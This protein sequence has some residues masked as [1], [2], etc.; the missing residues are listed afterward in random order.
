[1]CFGFVAVDGLDNFRVG[2]LTAPVYAGTAVDP[3]SYVRCGTTDANTHT[4]VAGNTLTVDCTVPA[5][6]KTRY[7]IIQS[8]DANAEHLCIGEVELE[9]YCESASALVLLSH[10]VADSVCRAFSENTHPGLSYTV[11]CCIIITCTFVRRCHVL[12]T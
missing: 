8:L 4:V 11:M 12:H 2:G 6:I 3:D 5:P 1:M 9:R 10:S 7:L